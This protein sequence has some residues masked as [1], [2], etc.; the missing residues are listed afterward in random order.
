MIYDLVSY[1]DSIL[2]EEMPIFDFSNMTIHPV[3]LYN[4]LAETMLKYN[5][6]GLSSNQVGLRYR[7]CVIRS[8]PIIGMYN[9]RI[10]DTSSQEIELDEACLSYPGIVIKRKRPRM[11]KVRYTKPDGDTVTEK[12]IDITARTILHEIDH[13]NG[14]RFF[15]KLSKFKKELLIEKL[16][17]KNMK[18]TIKDLL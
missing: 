18:Y 5:G 3:E 15:D 17:K 8:D 12:F 1:K 11:V 13:L 14:I 7:F 6:L 2:K 4:N 10:V 9:P 16:Q